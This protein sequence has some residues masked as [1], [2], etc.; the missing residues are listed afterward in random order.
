[1]T[2][3]ESLMRWPGAPNRMLPEH[4]EVVSLAGPEEDVGAAL[5]AVADELSTPAGAGS[6]SFARLNPPR[7]PLGALDANSLAAAVAATL[8]E[9]AIVV[10]E[11]ATSSVMLYPALA[12]AVPH[13]WL[14]LTGGAIGQGL[15]CATGA[16]IPAPIG[17]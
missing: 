4:T 7:R 15:P 5:A 6:G 9:D 8:P 12:C 14:T 17:V 13:T 2:G 1:M 10:D 11:G 16:A 3:A